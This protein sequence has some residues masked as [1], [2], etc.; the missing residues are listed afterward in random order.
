MLLFCLL[1]GAAYGAF[2]AGQEGLDRLTHFTPGHL[3]AT[4]PTAGTTPL[5]GRLVLIL[6]EG[7]R[8]EDAH[9]LPS[10]EWLRSAGS[11]YQLASSGSGREHALA[12]LLTGAP[13]PLQEIFWPEMSKSLQADHLLRSA[14]RAKVKSGGAGGPA[15]GRLTSGTVDTWYEG[16]S[17]EELPGGIASLLKPDGPRL[18]LLQVPDLLVQI[19]AAGTA[20]TSRADYRDA[21][22]GLDAGLVAIFDQIDW[23]A[24]TVLVAGTLP[25]DRSG[26]RLERGT[27]PLIM[28]GNAVRP[29]I[30]GDG[31]VLDLA[32]TAAAL[33]GLA[34]PLQ[35]QGKPLLGGLQVDGHP[36][37]AIMK[38]YLTTRRTFADLALQAYGATVG[39]PDPPVD[40]A[41][42]DPYLAKLDLSVS[43]AR[44]AWQKDGLLERLPY[45]GG[46]ILVL[47]LYVIIV[48]RQ[49]FGGTA[50][51]TALAYGVIFHL[52]FF[53][54][55]G[56]Y[57]IRPLNMEAPLPELRLRFGLVVVAA[58][59]A[60]ALVTG[61]LLS[62]K[63]FKRSSYLVTSALHTNLSLAALLT[64][65]V[66]AT[67]LFTGWTFPVLLPATGL[68]VW[69]FM[70]VLQVIVIGV[71]SPAWSFLAVQGVRIGRHLWPLPEVGDPEMNADKV[72]RLKAIKRSRNHGRR[73]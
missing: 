50:F 15:L 58:M 39:T 54:A 69:F 53:L 5:T 72:V 26:K 24:T 62:R 22:A 42:F 31:S 3:S 10:L 70:T 1:F 67:L 52:L 23:K 56:W 17:L 43:E 6:V 40:A 7:L 57:D 68:W 73:G 21:L 66:A 28:A 60:A 37:D 44:F 34:A 61:L 30:R 64:L 65:P 36:A 38:S 35:T 47:L 59:A 19:E 11:G 51:L 49:P 12:S 71:G 29:G 8:T 46:G 63:E 41:E 4:P 45:L 18:V 9:L 14:Q 48:W 55:G 13:P 2:R 32:P 16:H 27:V 25:L 20:D 33:L